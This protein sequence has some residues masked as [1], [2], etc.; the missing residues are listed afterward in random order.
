MSRKNRKVTL[1][2]PE[3]ALQ[4]AADIMASRAEE[5]DSPGGERSMET[6]VR[7]FNTLTGHNLST[8]DGWK[9]M[10]FLKMVRIQKAPFKADSYVDAINY[11]ALE[12]EEAGL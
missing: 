1:S 4:E 5:Y 9:F 10:Q 12:M 6:T 7:L 11:F 2:T 3:R 8:A